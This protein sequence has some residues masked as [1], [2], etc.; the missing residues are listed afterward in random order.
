MQSKKNIIE[1][2]FKF[3][4]FWGLPAIK[5]LGFEKPFKPSAKAAGVLKKMTWRVFDSLVLSYLRFRIKSAVKNG[6]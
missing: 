6:L 2:D 5:I 3:N 1:L 4:P